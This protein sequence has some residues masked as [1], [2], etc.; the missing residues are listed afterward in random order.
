MITCDDCFRRKFVID[1][2]LANTSREEED[3]E[4][5]DGDE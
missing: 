1:T 4:D 5:V 3:N 2:T